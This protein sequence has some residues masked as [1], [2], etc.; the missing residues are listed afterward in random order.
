M[1]RIWAHILACLKM[2]RGGVNGGGSMHCAFEFVAPN[3]T[4]VRYLM[5]HGGPPSQPKPT[6]QPLS[7]PPALGK[8]ANDQHVC[9]NDVHT[10]RR[11]FRLHRRKVARSSRSYRASVLANPPDNYPA[12][13][14]LLSV[15]PP[16]LAELCHR[17]HN[18]L[19]LA[20]SFNLCV[21]NDTGALTP[22]PTEHNQ[23]RDWHGQFPIGEGIKSLEEIGF[24][25]RANVNQLPQPRPPAQLNQPRFGGRV[26]GSEVGSERAG[27]L[28]ALG[29]TMMM[30]RVSPPCSVPKRLPGIALR[31]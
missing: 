28:C 2:P 20:V 13:V 19:V 22:P 8:I 12:P 14:C 10:H 27:L 29:C 16:F 18:K 1:S 9:G 15:C 6:V 26:G 31:S 11:F 5:R 3:E 30:A 21:L 24:Q 17:K 25:G 7:P 4:C 23:L